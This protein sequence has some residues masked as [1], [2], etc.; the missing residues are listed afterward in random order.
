M[1]KCASCRL[2][3]SDDIHLM[4]GMKMLYNMK[5]V[6][7][8]TFS[9]KC[10]TQSRSQSPLIILARGGGVEKLQ[11]YSPDILTVKNVQ[12]YPPRKIFQ[13]FLCLYNL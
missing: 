3:R 5:V 8:W 12:Q 4:L 9:I 7:I 13:M 11:K 2:Y 10:I 1:G 6:Y